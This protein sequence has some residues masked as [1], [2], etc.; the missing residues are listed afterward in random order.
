MAG[1][2]SLLTTVNLTGIA[3]ITIAG[4]ESDAEINII[5]R[6]TAFKFE[7]V[8]TLAIHG[9]TFELHS[10]DTHG[11]SSLLY[12]SNVGSATISNS[13]F[14][15]GSGNLI[16]NMV[17]A[18][19]SHHSVLT[20]VSCHF[21]GGTAR[22]GGAVYASAGSTLD[23]TG[24]TFVANK[25]KRSGGAIFAEHSTITLNLTS[26]ANNSCLKMGGALYCERTKVVIIGNT[27]FSITDPQKDAF[28]TISP[29]FLANKARFGGAVFLHDS[30]ASLNGSVISFRDNSAVNGGGIYTTGLRTRSA[31]VTEVKYLYFISNEAS[32]SG[33]A[34]Y[35]DNSNLVLQETYFFNN[36]AR[37]LGGAINSPDGGRLTMMGIS[38]FAYN[39]VVPTLNSDGSAIAVKFGNFLLSGK[40]TFTRNEA[41]GSGTVAIF[42]C[43][44][45]LYGEIEFTDNSANRGGGIAVANT[46]SSKPVVVTGTFINN[47]AERG[48]AL[49]IKRAGNV[50]C[51]NVS[52]N[53]NSI[54]IFDSSVTFGETTVIANNNGGGVHSENS[55]I[56]FTDYSLFENNS[57]MIGG[58]VSSL[59]GTITFSG[60]SMFKENRAE[61]K[62]GAL[63][64]SGTG[65]VFKDSVNVVSNSAQYGGAMYLSSL[66]SLTLSTSSILNSS[67]NHASQYGGVIYHEDTALPVQCHFEIQDA[68]SS[69]EVQLPNCFIQL[70]SIARYL[71]PA[72]TSYND[73]AIR[74][75]SYLYGGLLDKCLLIVTNILGEII[76]PIPYTL[77]SNTVIQLEG[78]DNSSARGVSSQPYQLCFCEDN[79]Q[80]TCAKIQNR[81]VYRG[82][83]FN[84]S[85][86]AIAEGGTTVSTLV[87]TKVSSTARLRLNQTI[88]N[89]SRDCADLE[90]NLYS[91]QSQEEL[92]L[93][94]DGPCRDTGLAKTVINVTLLPCPDGFTLSTEE[95][96]CEE[97]L[98]D[99]ANC[100][101]D[102]KADIVRKSGSTFWASG[103]YENESYQG[104]ILNIDC[105][106]NY[107]KTQTLVLSLRNP[108]IQCDLNRGGLLC[109]ACATNYSL[110]LGGT[111]CDICPDTYF[112]LLL[113]FAAAGIFLVIFLSVLR[114]TVATGMLNSVILFANIVQ[115]N[116]HVFLPTGRR[117][118]LTVFI[119]WLN[120]DLGIE[121]CFYDGMDAYAQTWL[122]FAFPV[123]LWILIS[124]IILTSRYSL[125]VSKLI[126]HNPVAVLA[127]LLLMSYT[128]ILRVIIEVYSFT[129][130]RYPQKTVKVWLKDANVSYLQ[131]EHLFLTV[132]TTLVLVFLFLPYTFLLLLGYKLYRFS[133][134]KYLKWLNRVKLLLDP[135]YAP[136]KMHTRYWTGFLLIVRCALYT[137][138]SF[139]TT[140]NSLI[141]IIITFSIIGITSGYLASGKI[142]NKL[143]TNVLEASLYLQL[144]ILS[145]V[146]LAEVNL[147]VVTF[148]LAN[149][150]LLIIVIAV[151][152]Y[153]IHVHILLPVKSA[154]WPKM[155]AY[156]QKRIVLKNATV[157]SNVEVNETSESPK[158]ITTTMI[159]LR[160]SLLES[161]SQLNCS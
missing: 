51:N 120:L 9:L 62:G 63:Y 8:T 40:A 116:K 7:D 66:A 111:R 103:L 17:R 117:N 134:R 112:T 155:V 124:L 142:Y 132:V 29:I 3:N 93:Y 11:D 143:V 154:L 30:K 44:A 65:I 27:S 115:V 129:R 18:I 100:T 156:C 122:Q 130:L 90:Y 107:C 34:I 52:V 64:A 49:F 28:T 113:P 128:K 118:I 26:F 82:Q 54:Y 45:S 39:R 91:T 110:M 69:L 61:T 76:R 14:Q 136:Y 138:F 22:N 5:C 73:T 98:Q 139:G 20:V 108:D 87:T 88:Q 81:T 99:Y 21:T 68:Q 135:Y 96:V 67:H 95:C 144:I 47:T 153:H 114:L 150:I 31:I 102:E 137:V 33:G 74:D 4:E 109:G 158:V 159:D 43:T 86:V 161:K 19:Y 41:T 25:A 149:G 157:K 106:F 16:K 75:G 38:Y 6:N 77:L 85:L 127:T 12:F 83:R 72:V 97:R 105:P 80:H 10:N 55:Y 60:V 1:N 79:L 94:P 15:R 123:Y 36:S 32:S 13:K 104:V 24:S 146:N 121:T 92:I 125:T 89:I 57:A 131:S 148:S 147:K 2:H 35:T 23:L 59:Y 119:A 71:I 70:T 141:A 58:A 78:R 140:S 46:D 151:I 126:G 133:D 84:I 101:I 53:C 50:T 145:A 160:E 48:G 37:T 56:S 42:S 152:L